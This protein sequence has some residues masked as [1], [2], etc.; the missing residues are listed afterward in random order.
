MINLAIWHGF[1]VL[2][3]RLIGHIR[4]DFKNKKIL[5]TGS[6]CLSADCWNLED[7]SLVLYQETIRIE[8]ILIVYGINVIP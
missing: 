5:V 3:H 6:D 2:L 7:N 4:V 1:K 8:S